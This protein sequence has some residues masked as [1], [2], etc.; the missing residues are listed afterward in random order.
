MLINTSNDQD[1]EIVIGLV[2]PLGSNLDRLADSLDRELSNHAYET[3]VIRLSTLLAKDA[4][5]TSDPKS[6][7]SQSESLMNAGDNLRRNFDSGDVVAALGLAQIRHSRHKDGASQNQRRRYA[8]IIRT[9]KHDEEVELLR[10][11]YGSRFVLIGVNE[12]ESQR[13][14]NFERI[15]RSYDPLLTGVSGVAAKLLERDEEDIGEKHGQRVRETNSLADFYVEIGTRLIHDVKRIVALLFGQP[16]ETPTRDEQAMYHA[17]AA[18]LR[19][20]DSGRQVGAVITT[21]DGDIIAT[22]TNEV[23]KPGGGQYWNGDHNDQRDF[24]I[25]H[26]YNK[27]QNNRLLQEVLDILS[28][29][30]FLASGVTGM[31]SAKRLETVLESSPKS[32]KKS[33]AVSLIEFGRISHA[34][35]S[36]ITDCSRHGKPTDGATIYVS[37]FPCHMCMRLIIASGIAR[38][39]YVD[40][41]PKSLSLEMYGA[42]TGGHQNLSAGIIAIESFRGASWRVFPRVFSK[43][44]RKRAPDG[45]FASFSPAER[46]FRWTDGEDLELSARR[47]AAA[48][49]K[50]TSPIGESTTHSGWRKDAPDSDT[51]LT[52]GGEYWGVIKSPNDLSWI[53][54]VVVEAQESLDSASH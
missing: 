32:F 2:A 48:V 42:M 10:Y 44:N 8:W 36:A 40:P 28:N 31:S 25:G 7:E 39:V 23:P 52:S 33:R 6:Q 34:E 14:I 5:K 45:Q 41:Y 37:A 19:S 24:Q 22:G 13:K 50:L 30:G 12:V 17:Y 53:E 54:F 18:S 26:D 38:I 29:G 16:F 43:I 3:E 4:D 9:L 35:M 21:K 1:H 27:L 15:L 11:I 51:E 20:S 47:E 46:L 49:A